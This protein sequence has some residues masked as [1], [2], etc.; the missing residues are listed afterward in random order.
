MRSF[1]PIRIAGLRSGG[2]SDSVLMAI[3]MAWPDSVT[4]VNCVAFGL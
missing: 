2:R 4:T 1:C 3:V